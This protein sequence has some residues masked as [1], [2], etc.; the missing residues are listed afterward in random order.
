MD[1]EMRGNKI[2][3]VAGLISNAKPKNFNGIQ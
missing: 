2:E 3:T 1:K